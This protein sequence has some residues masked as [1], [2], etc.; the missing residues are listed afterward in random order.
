MGIDAVQQERKVWY[1]KNR[2][3]V[4]AKKRSE[5]AAIKLKKEKEAFNIQSVEKAKAYQ[6][7]YQKGYRGGVR[8]MEEVYRAEVE[9][10]REENKK[11]V[12]QLKTLKREWPTEERIDIIGPNGNTGDHYAILDNLHTT[13]ANQHAKKSN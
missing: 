5:Y 3:E 7:T 13:G 11:L 2:V 10:L 4:L 9:H 8:K 12:A 1:Q 6:N